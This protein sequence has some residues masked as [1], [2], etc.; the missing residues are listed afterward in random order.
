MKSLVIAAAV[1]AAASASLC[2]LSA[3]AGALVP[4][5]AHARCSNHRVATLT[6]GLA[7]RRVSLWQC[8]STGSFHASISGGHAGDIVWVRNGTTW[9]RVTARV[10]SGHTSV[11]TR[12]LG[13]GNGQTVWACGD[14]TGRTTSQCTGHIRYTQP[15]GPGPTIP[16]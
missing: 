5:T 16:G 13:I 10:S 2:A 6:K 15:G 11:S 4:S 14:P 12:A 1:L 3:P 8:G 7:G 9:A